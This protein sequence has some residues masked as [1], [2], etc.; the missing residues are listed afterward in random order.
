MES[1]VATVG[2]ISAPQPPDN[3]LGFKA[4]H[5]SEFLKVTDSGARQD[6]I[7]RGDFPTTA[8]SKRQPIVLAPLMLPVAGPWTHYG[9]GFLWCHGTE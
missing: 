5:C 2:Y 3:S 1:C 8:K 6:I 9:L 7:G 4:G